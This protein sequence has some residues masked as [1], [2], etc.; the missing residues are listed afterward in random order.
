MKTN[1]RKTQTNIRN[2]QVLEVN[3]TG[4]LTCPFLTEF[5]E[6]EIVNK[7]CS[8]SGYAIDQVLITR[9]DKDSGCKLN[10]MNVHVKLKTE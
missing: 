8:L 4:C 7:A 9:T 1:H 3:V 5:T 6:L 2:L 10:N